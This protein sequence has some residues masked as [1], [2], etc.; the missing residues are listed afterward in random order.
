MEKTGGTAADVRG[1]EEES[2]RPEVDVGVGVVKALRKAPTSGLLRIR[3]G[4]SSTME[5]K[6]RLCSTRLHDAH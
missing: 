2:V 4:I 3:R 1:V 5:E 6:V